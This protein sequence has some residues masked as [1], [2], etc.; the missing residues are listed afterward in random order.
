MWLFTKVGFFSVV[1]ETYKTKGKPRLVV[2]ARV[3]ADLEKLREVYAPRLGATVQE[4]GRDYPYRAFITKKALAAVLERVVLD[5]DYGNFKNKVRQEQGAAREHM[6]HDV[7]AVMNGAERKL[8]GVP[9]QL[10]QDRTHQNEAVTET[11]DEM[12]MVICE[13]LTD[14][15]DATVTR[16]FLAMDAS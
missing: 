2:R 15:D 16:M 13:R 10:D 12:E 8:A 7:W 6:Y 9:V 5:I 4:P 11:R 1:L 14:V 3:G